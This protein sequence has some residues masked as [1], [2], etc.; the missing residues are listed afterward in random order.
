MRTLAYVEYRYPELADCCPSGRQVITKWE[1][2]RRLAGSQD[3]R[4][5][6]AGIRAALRRDPTALMLW[7]VLLTTSARRLA[8]C[9]ATELPIR[10][11]R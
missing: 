7:R 9:V 3:Y 2:H 5:I 1:A 8:N 11:E 4:W 6:T 10:G